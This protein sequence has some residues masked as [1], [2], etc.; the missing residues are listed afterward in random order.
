MG[1]VIQQPLVK[2]TCPAPELPHCVSKY[3]TCGA[4]KIQSSCIMAL[5][6]MLMDLLHFAIQRTLIK[7][8]VGPLI[9]CKARLDL[10]IL[11]WNLE[12]DLKLK[13]KRKKDLFWEDSE[14]R[15][16]IRKVYFEHFCL[17]YW[18]SRISEDVFSTYLCYSNVWSGVRHVII[19]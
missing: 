3:S 1:S 17:I 9:K 8:K 14:A 5:N 12:W 11:L 13:K 15:I 19:A 10:G 7:P 4:T 16:L 6:D 18:N 2:S